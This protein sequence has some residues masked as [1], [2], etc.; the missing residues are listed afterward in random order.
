[1][2]VL[3]GKERVVVEWTDQSLGTYEGDEFYGNEDDLSQA[4]INQW[5]EEGEVVSLPRYL[6][7][8]KEI[9]LRDAIGIND[10]AEMVCEQVQEVWDRESFDDFPYKE[11]V[12]FLSNWLEQHHKGKYMLEVDYDHVVDL[13]KVWEPFIEESAEFD[14]RDVKFVIEDKDV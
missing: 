6:Y 13:T 11:L 14:D 5:Y 1:M 9:P 4:Y 12:P 3:N 2:V 10:L 7:V 8:A